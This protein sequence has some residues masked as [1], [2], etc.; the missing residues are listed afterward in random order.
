MITE[1]TRL[2]VHRSSNLEI[3]LDLVSPISSSV[4]PFLRDNQ[5]KKVRGKYVLGI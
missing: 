3:N 5:S 2:V 1:I 4:I